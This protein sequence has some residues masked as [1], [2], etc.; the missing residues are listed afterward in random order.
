VAEVFCGLADFEERV[1]VTINKIVLKFRSH[2]PE[3]WEIYAGWPRF[4][5]NPPFLQ[6]RNL[7]GSIASNLQRAEC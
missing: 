6:R 5:V 7:S 3:L 2:N 4:R 1:S